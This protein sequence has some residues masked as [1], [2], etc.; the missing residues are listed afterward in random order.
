MDYDLIMGNSQDGAYDKVY[1][2]F[3]LGVLFFGAGYKGIYDDGKGCK[4]GIYQHPKFK[5]QAE[6]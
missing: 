3:F 5:S 2:W 1:F 4:R 6:I